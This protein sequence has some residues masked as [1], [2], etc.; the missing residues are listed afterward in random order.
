MEIGYKE[1]KWAMRE[2]NPKLTCKQCREI[3]DTVYPNEQTIP[4]GSV[5]SM[6]AL[7]TIA[8]CKTAVPSGCYDSIATP[9]INKQEGITPMCYAKAPQTNTAV[10]AV[11][12]PVSIEGTQ[13]DFFTQRIY[14]EVEKH[15]AA[16]RKQFNMDAKDKPETAKAL[17]KAIT[18]GDYTLDDAVLDKA[19]ESGEIRYY[20]AFFGIRWGKTKPDHAGYAVAKAALAVASQDAIDAGTLA[21]AEELLQLLKDFQ[22]WTFTAK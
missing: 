4:C 9:L 5:I 15:G 7:N 14:A 8:S 3:Y 11:S 13:R 20:N 17:I 19:E 1:F 18:E 16:L 6:E 10:L 22:E 2:C 21:P 12:A